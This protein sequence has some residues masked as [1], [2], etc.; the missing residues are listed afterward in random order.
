MT[1]SSARTPSAPALTRGSVTSARGVFGV[2]GGVVADLLPGGFEGDLEVE[3]GFHV[4][5]A[6]QAGGDEV[7]GAEV[8]L[9]R[10]A[11][12]ATEIARGELGVVG[13]DHV[14]AVG[15]GE[16]LFGDDDAGQVRTRPPLATSA[17]AV[18]HRLRIFDLVGD[19][20]AEAAPF[21]R[22]GHVPTPSDRV[23][24]TRVRRYHRDSGPPAQIS[25]RRTPTW[26][27]RPAGR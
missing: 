2:L 23:V 27:V 7:V 6:H 11:A 21:E 22:V 1:G 18:A 24:E 16:V 26:T 9:D 20:A 10:A 17:M 13:F 3:G 19:A 4:E 14:V 25:P 12:V 15:E 8:V 5:V